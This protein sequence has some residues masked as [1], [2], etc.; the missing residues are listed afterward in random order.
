MIETEE[1]TKQ[2]DKLFA[3][4]NFIVDLVESDMQGFAALVDGMFARLSAVLEKIGEFV[5]HG[6]VL[7]QPSEP[8]PSRRRIRP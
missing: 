8:L 6:L 3:V 4:D 5:K 1:L 7:K 2:Y